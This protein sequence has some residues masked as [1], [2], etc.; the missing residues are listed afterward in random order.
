MSSVHRSASHERTLEMLFQH[1]ISNNI[2]W[3]Q[4]VALLQAIGT[5]SEA[6]NGSLH[7]TVNNE[8]VVLHRPK[9]KDVQEELV[10]R[11]RH[12]LVRAG[13]EPP[14]VTKGPTGDSASS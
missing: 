8:S 12:F 2:E 1:P 14:P 11:I 13:I 7:V 9:H 4:V 3:R 5:A 6:S 10:M